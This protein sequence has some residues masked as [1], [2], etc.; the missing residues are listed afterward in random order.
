M[1][2]HHKYTDSDQFDSGVVEVSSSLEEPSESTMIVNTDLLRRARAGYTQRDQAYLIVIS[3]PHVG[4]MY[5]IDREAMTLGRSPQVDIQLND[6]GVSRH[7]VRVESRGDEVFVRDLGSANGTFINGLQVTSDYRLADGD[8]ITLGTTTI[9]KFT[10]HDRLD[11]TFQRDLINAAQRDGLTGAYNKRHMMEQLRTEMS[12]ALR[13][14]THLSMVMFDVDHFKRTNDTFGHL[15]GDHVLKQLAKLSMDSVRDEDL[16]ARYGGEEFLILCRG[17]DI[18][19]GARLGNRI[20][21]LTEHTQFVYN[22]Q[23]IPVTISVG[24]SGIPGTDA[25]T[26][27]ELIAGTDEALYAAKNAGRNC[28]MIKGS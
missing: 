18:Q 27:E 15:A 7:H 20:R 19:Q 11:E 22:N 17:I 6:L 4:R 21:K 23:H 3:G 5:K 28:V 10:Y 1:S 24:V 26:P 2:E 13:H 8:K 16:F 14:G 9:L 25:R 12:Y